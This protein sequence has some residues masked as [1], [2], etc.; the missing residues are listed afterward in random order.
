MRVRLKGWLAG[1]LTA[2]GLLLPAGPVA[3]APATDCTLYAAATG[4]DSNSGLDAAHPKTLDGANAAAVP[5]SVICLK[6]GTYY[7]ARPL[8]P[9][10]GTASAYVVFKAYGDSPAA[11]VW[12]GP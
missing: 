11:L 12:T 2:V 8:Y 6:G 7:R 9:T 10:S 5:G 1:V 4:S 3:A